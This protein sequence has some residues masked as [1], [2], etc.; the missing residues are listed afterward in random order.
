M[1]W[2][3][4]L[5]PVAFVIERIFTYIVLCFLWPYIGM[6]LDGYLCYVWRP[7]IKRREVGELIAFQSRVFQTC[8]FQFFSSVG[9]ILLL[10]LWGLKFSYVVYLVYIFFCELYV[11]RHTS[12]A[13]ITGNRIFKYGALIGLSIALGLLSL[14][15]AMIK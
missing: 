3:L 9:A 13:S 14:I 1:L 11:I 5:F 6:W 10:A 8:F 7:L 12:V 15:A 4:L 2:K